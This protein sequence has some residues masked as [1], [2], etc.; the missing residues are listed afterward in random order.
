MIDAFFVQL[1]DNFMSKRIS[2]KKY[3]K[4]KHWEEI[5]SK[6]AFDENAKC[7]F[8]GAE[9]WG[10]YKRGKNKG[11]RKKR[12]INHLHLHHKHYDNLMNESREDFLLLCDSCHKLGHLLEK[13]KNKSDEYKN[14]Y[15]KMIEL[16][17][18]F[19]KRHK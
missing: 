5:R 1:K 3:Y 6:Y 12:Q 18:I 16:G 19:K 14:M 15:L 10:I 17:W 11:K 9:R 7:E 4:T 2:L 13:M 8:C